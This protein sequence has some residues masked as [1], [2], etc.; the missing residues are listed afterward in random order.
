MVLLNRIKRTVAVALFVACDINTPANALPCHTDTL[1]FIGTGDIMMGTSYPSTAYLPPGDCSSLFVHVADFL[2]GADITFG[3]LEGTLADTTAQPRKC[4]DT[5]NCYI[6]RMPASFARCLAEAGYDVVSVANNHAGDFGSAGKE[7]TVNAL[8]NIGL[9]YAGTN[10]QPCT[11]LTRSGYRIALCAFATSGGTPSLLDTA[12]AKTVVTEAAR[13]CDI[14]IVSMHGGAEGKDHQH[15]T[16][17]DEEFLGYPRGNVQRFAH[18]MID[19]GADIVFGHGPHVTRAVEL[20][21]DRFIAYSL[22]NFCTYSR[23]NLRGPNGYAPAIKVF[24]DPRGGF[25]RAEVLPVRQPGPGIPHP[26]PG[27]TAVHILRE[28]SET[29]FPESMLLINGDGVIL[30][31]E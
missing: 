21:R 29:D 4:R 15:V 31:K 10:D 6:F 8:R 22:G 5:V 12:Y 30:R 26:D 2:S 23:F 7:Q 17:Q 11:F 9:Y 20:Y 14:V 1:T 16:R 3:N 28:L 13:E 25:I 24:T 18:A 27:R 19:A